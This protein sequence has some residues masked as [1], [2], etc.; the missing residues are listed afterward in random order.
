MESIVHKL[1]L[2]VRLTCR[3]SKIEFFAERSLL[4]EENR[5][6][7]G[8]ERRRTRSSSQMSKIN[9]ESRSRIGIKDDSTCMRVSSAL[10]KLAGEIASEMT[11][12]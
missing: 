7:E 5:K 10:I 6:T 9:K 2:L 3:L 8:R 12:S 1:D 4:E 11:D